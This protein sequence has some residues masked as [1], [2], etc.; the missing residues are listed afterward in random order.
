M[1]SYKCKDIGMTCGFEVRDENQD[2]LMQV[3]GLHGEKTHNM[4]A[5]FPPDMM[6][7]IKGAIKT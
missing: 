2:E 7:K 6:E 4:K 1:P 5:P 3:I